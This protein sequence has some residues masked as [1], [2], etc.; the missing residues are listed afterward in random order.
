[1][2]NVTFSGEVTA[3]EGEGLEGEGVACEGAAGEDAVTGEMRQKLLFAIA[4]ESAD[5]A[6]SFFWVAAAASVS[7]DH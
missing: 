4:E 2:G 7:L 3:G 5:S 1:M 6:T